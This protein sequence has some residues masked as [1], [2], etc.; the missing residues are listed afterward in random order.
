MI[1]TESKLRIV[2]VETRIVNAQLRNWVFVKIRTSEDGLIGWGEA[3]LEWRSRAVAG[4]VE[5]LAPLL[6]GQDPMRI[7]FL[8]QEMYRQHFFKGGAVTMSA[9]SGIDQALYDIAGKVHGVPVYELLG[10]R[11]RDEVRFYDHLGGGQKDSVYGVEVG[12][13]RLAELAAAS[14]EEGFDALKFLPLD[15][16]PALPSAQ[17]LDRATE[18]L[19]A[20]RAAV[21]REVDVM[22]DLH[23]RSSVPAAIRLAERMREFDPWFLEEPCQPEDV[24]GMARV[25]RATSIPVAAGER[26]FTRYGFRPL[27]EASACAIVQPDVCHCGGLTEIRKIASIADTY[28]VAVAPHN[29]LGPVATMASLHFAFSTPNFLI[30]EVMRSDVPWRDDIVGDALL[31]DHGRAAP[32]L[33]PGLGIEI[34]E[35]AAAKHPF[36]P[37]P[38]L[39]TYYADGSVGDW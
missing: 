24:D 9:I 2:A 17:P 31:L 14:I 38:Q 8:W 29:P 13:G 7:E 11:V 36:V 23:G 37:E 15:P 35:R 3:T 25:A 12:L 20:V 10:G 19:A 32:P 16:I 18:R 6:V 33:R 27:L 28:G 1:Y 21:G 39:M 4:A 30:Q 5:D 26:I 22:V 34:D